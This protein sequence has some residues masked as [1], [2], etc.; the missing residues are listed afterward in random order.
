MSGH[1]AVENNNV[2]FVLFALKVIAAPVARNSIFENKIFTAVLKLMDQGQVVDC[3]QDH[4]NTTC[5]AKSCP[6]L[7]I[8]FEYGLRNAINKKQS[9]L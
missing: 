4:L 2:Q 8:S 9:V 3:I 1:F 7:W 5:K 6:G